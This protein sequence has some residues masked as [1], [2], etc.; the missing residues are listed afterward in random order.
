[1]STP[2]SPEQAGPYAIAQ[3]YAAGELSW[4]ETLPLLAEWHYEPGF[5][6]ADDTDELGIEPGGSFR[7]TVGRALGD[8]LITVVQYDQVLDARDVLREAGRL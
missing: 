3:R 4:E 5:Q 6:P 1:M 8:G 7:S 2:Q